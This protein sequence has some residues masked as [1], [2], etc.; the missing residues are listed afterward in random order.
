MDAKR[1]TLAQAKRSPQWQRLID[2]IH[3]A[4]EAKGY[5]G[6]QFGAAEMRYFGATL[7]GMPAERVNWGTR[8]PQDFAAYWV[9]RQAF[10]HSDGS[11]SVRYVLKVV[12]GNDL[13]NVNTITQSDET[14]STFDPSPEWDATTALDFVRRAHSQT[15]RP[16]P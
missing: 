5:P 7:I 1:R 16:T 10:D 12:Y 2:S 13:A 15:G 6:R 9:E 3:K 14:E 8:N 4:Q 11:Q